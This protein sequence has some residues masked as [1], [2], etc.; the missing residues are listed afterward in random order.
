M[1]V[2]PAAIDEEYIC[3]L[4]VLSCLMH[5]SFVGGSQCV[6]AHGVF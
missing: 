4:L 2:L 6:V 1:L 3:Q 5:G